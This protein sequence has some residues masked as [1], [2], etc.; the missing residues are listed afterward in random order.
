M[1]RRI[2]YEQTILDVK[3]AVAAKTNVPVEKQQLFLRGAE[4][5]PAAYD[6]KTLMELNMH[7]GFALQGY[8]L[9]SESSV[10][11]HPLTCPH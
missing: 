9:V 6:A 3:K 7:T 5:T 4:L 1:L 11:P 10:V 2:K 8:D